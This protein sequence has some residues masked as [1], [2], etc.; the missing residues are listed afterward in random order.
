MSTRALKA[1]VAVIKSVRSM[2]RP[3]FHELAKTGD[4]I[5]ECL[6]RLRNV[7]ERFE[8]EDYKPSPPEIEA[9]KRFAAN[10]DFWAAKV[11]EFNEGVEVYTAAGYDNYGGDDEEFSRHFIGEHI[12][13][14]IGSRAVA[15][16]SPEMYARV[17]RL[18]NRG[19]GRMGA[20]QPRSES[21]RCSD[22]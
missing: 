19:S 22:K 16:H 21:R 15:P 10:W 3:N 7:V 5:V 14:M 1:N 17:M 20:R 12:A 18:W 13:K 11:A 2:A 9:A 6:D 8:G 4:D